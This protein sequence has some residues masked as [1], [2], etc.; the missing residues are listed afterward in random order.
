M[1]QTLPSEGYVRLPQILAV[2]PV[3]PTTWWRGVKSGKFP[4]PIKLTE[5]TTAWDVSEIRA[6]LEKSSESS[7]R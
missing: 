4:K 3:S 5:R 2:F 6:L 1:H 7:E